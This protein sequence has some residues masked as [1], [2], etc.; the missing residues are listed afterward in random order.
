MTVIITKWNSHWQNLF[1]SYHF[2]KEFRNTI[3]GREEKTL[4]TSCH[5]TSKLSSLACALFSPLFQSIPL[6]V[7]AD[8][9][10]PSRSLGSSHNSIFLSFIFNFSPSGS[11]ATGLNIFKFY[12]HLFKKIYPCPY[13]LHCLL[14]H[15]LAFTSE[16]VLCKVLNEF[17]ITASEGH[18]SVL[19][20]L[21]VAA[22][23]MADSSWWTTLTSP[24]SHFFGYFL[25]S[26]LD[27]Y[28]SVHTLNAHIFLRRFSC[29]PQSCCEETW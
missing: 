15:S 16:V 1:S 3:R 17:L 13:G 9:I 24:S 2:Q 29:F 4:S 19:S 5:E 28:V 27:S 10:P 22:G 6:S 7:S 21:T 18:V 8:P 23:H 20:P 12:F 26:I 25:F 11:F 14:V